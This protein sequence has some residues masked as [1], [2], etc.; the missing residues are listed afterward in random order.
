MA[1]ANTTN[2]GPEI[3]NSSA[4]DGTNSDTDESEVVDNTTG[5]SAD[6]NPSED[7]TDDSS[8]ID[9]PVST[10]QP[11][12]TIDNISFFGMIDVQI[13][14]DMH[15][16]NICLVCSVIFQCRSSFTQ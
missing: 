9:N 12:I 13:G 1:D 14:G 16:L 4:G 7:S 8:S 10:D 5:N 6:D 15:G 11:A 3:E 2:A